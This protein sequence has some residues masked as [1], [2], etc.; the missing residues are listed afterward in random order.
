[1]Q[2]FP[3]LLVGSDALVGFTQVERWTSFAAVKNNNADAATKLAAT[4]VAESPATGEA[5][6]YYWFRKVLADAGVKVRVCARAHM[7]AVGWMDKVLVLVMVA[8]SVLLLH[9]SPPTSLT[10]PF[11][12]PFI[13]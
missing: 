2:D 4:G 8:S 5:S 3:K 6:A 7:W 10:K 13:D 12:G 9:F 1:M 11:G